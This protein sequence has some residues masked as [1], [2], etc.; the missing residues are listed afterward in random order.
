MR[1]SQ[2]VESLTL[3]SNLQNCAKS[4][5]Q[6]DTSSSDCVQVAACNSRV[7]LHNKLGPQV[8]RKVAVTAL[9]KQQSTMCYCTS[10]RAQACT[11]SSNC[12]QVPAAAE[13]NLSQEHVLKQRLSEVSPVAGTRQAPSPSQAFTYTIYFTQS[14]SYFFG[15]F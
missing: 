5:A 4:Y 7:F 11:S 3:C 9:K 14:C 10:G 12:K 13:C 6:V 2:Q 15:V 8:Q 1:H